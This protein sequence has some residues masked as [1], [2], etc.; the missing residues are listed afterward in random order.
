MNQYILILML[1]GLAS[2]SVSW[3]PKIS[4][5]TRISYSVFYVL[6]GFIVY[7]LFPR[8]LPDPLP[9]H[10]PEISLHLTELVVIISLMGAGI[11]ID[12]PFS[13]KSWAIP[14]KLVTITMVLSIAFS[15][16][17]G[18]YFLSLGLASAILLGACLAPTD[19]VLAADV[20]VAP[21]NETIKS[22]TR[23]SLTAEAGLN[24][25][26][27]F[28]F[29]WLAITV[30]LVTTTNA[31]GL[32]GQWFTFDVLY[33]IILGLVS[34]YLLG[35]FIGFIIFKL[36]NQYELLQTRDGLVA[37]SATLVVYSI[38]EFMSGYGFIA[39]FVCAI[40]LRHYEKGNAYHTELHSFSDQ[41]E[42]MLVSVLLILFGGMLARG[43]L[44]PLDWK[45][46]GFGIVFMFFI[47]PVSGLLTLSATKI[48]FHE[49]LG[50]SFFGIRG[51][52][53]V[54]YLSFA[55]SEFDFKYQD[56]IW[57]I[58]AFVILL[59]IIIH[60]FTATRVMKKLTKT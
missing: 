53:T 34:G 25:G 49:K 2:F 56:R 20:Q 42:R 6:I 28:P 4:S 22:E 14:L 52:G 48:S 57:A 3:M 41:I 9:A 39:V 29:V 40:S 16:F 8:Q 45:M 5:Y 27:A 35:K 7:S 55:F 54:F 13:I 10:H 12:R 24:D 18:Y 58:G 21:P 33:R 30:G 59:S 51:V 15:V 36:S 44:A 1:I 47:R 60:G 43:I 19:P 50:I 11:K 37:I 26:M 38:T 23:F 46:A 32:I 17:L 31:H